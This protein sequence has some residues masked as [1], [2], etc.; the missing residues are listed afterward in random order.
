MRR[1]PLTDEQRFAQLFPT[2]A[3]WA[4]ADKAADAVSPTEPMTKHVDAWVKGYVKA[5]GRRPKVLD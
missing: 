4:A 1:K 5:G 3:A 2:R